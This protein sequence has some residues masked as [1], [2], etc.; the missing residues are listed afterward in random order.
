MRT[1]PQISSRARALATPVALL[2]CL[3]VPAIAVAQHGGHSGGGHRSGGH[4]SGGHSSGGHS[5]G[6]HSGGGHRSGG[7]SSGGHSS[8]GHSVDGH[9]SGGHSAGVRHHR[10]SGH[11][12]G[13]L[14]FHSYFGYPYYYPYYQHGGPYY[15]DQYR[16]PYYRRNAYLD[17]GEMG[18]LDLDLQPGRTAVYDEGRYLGTVD[19]FDGFPAYL[20]LSPGTHELTFYLEGYRTIV[21]QFTVG[22]GQ[23][24]SVSESLQR[25]DSIMPGD[26][27]TGEPAE[28]PLRDGQRRR[29]PTTDLRQAPGRLSLEVVPADASVY[30]DGRFVGTG[31]DLTEGLVIDPGRHSLEVVRPDRRS[32]TWSFDVAPGGE[33]E[34]RIEL[35]PHS[36]MR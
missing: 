25:G 23:I 10:G 20:W 31:E 17:A 12:G 9:R 21:R 3:L 16:A 11:L 7:H 26:L 30:L 19:D 29:R 35:E 18:A 32:T 8:G 33:I 5:S 22:A 2:A 24:A 34:Q 4:S 6:G 1:Q 14:S 28:R 27:S 36:E 15:Y 13:Y